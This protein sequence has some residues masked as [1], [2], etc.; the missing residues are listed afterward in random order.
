VIGWLI[1]FDFTALQQVVF[2]RAI[3]LLLAGG[4]FIQR[5]WRVGTCN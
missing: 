3:Y 2:A 5:V 1:V 4:G